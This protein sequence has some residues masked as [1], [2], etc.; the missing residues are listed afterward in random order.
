MQVFGAA[1]ECLRLDVA[2][3]DIDL[4]VLVLSPDGTLWWNDDRIPGVD[5]KPLVKI[6]NTPRRGW[7][8]VHISHYDGLPRYSNFVLNYGRYSAAN[9]NCASPT[10]PIQPSVTLR[11]S[12]K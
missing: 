7:Y 9:L 2:S 5:R 6:S 12:L 10:P 11:Q 8:T 4:E 1:G 3:Q